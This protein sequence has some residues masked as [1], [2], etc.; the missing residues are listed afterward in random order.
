MRNIKRILERGRLLPVK[1]GR[2]GWTLLRKRKSS[3]PPMK[4]FSK[5]KGK[6]GVSSRK[7]Y[8]AI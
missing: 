7:I 5:K 4:Y 8:V 2:G 1:N 6:F 3:K